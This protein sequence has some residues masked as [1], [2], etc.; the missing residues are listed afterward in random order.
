[1]KKGAHEGHPP[2]VGVLSVYNQDAHE[3]G[4]GTGGFKPPASRT[5]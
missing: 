3:G 5:L 1:M 4:G 2:N